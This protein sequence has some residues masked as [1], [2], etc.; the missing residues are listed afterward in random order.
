[1]KLENEQKVYLKIIK[2]TKTIKLLKLLLKL[3]R[4]T[5]YLKIKNE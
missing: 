5:D 3:K 4:K 2:M 1:M